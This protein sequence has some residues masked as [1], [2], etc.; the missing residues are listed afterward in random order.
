MDKGLRIRIRPGSKKRLS[1]FYGVARDIL[2]EPPDIPSMSPIG[3][4]ILKDSW[5]R[6]L[7]DLV[8]ALKG[9]YDDGYG[10]AEKETERT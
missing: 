5:L 8:V 10:S 9:A 6:L 1:D 4:E 2:G 7:D 3:K